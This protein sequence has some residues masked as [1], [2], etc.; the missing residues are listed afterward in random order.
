VP[1]NPQARTSFADDSDEDLIFYM[2]LQA[3]D[4]A[5]A[6]EAWEEFFLRHREYVLGVCRR[7]QATLGDLGVE[8]LA[9]ETLIRVFKKAY[10][11]NPLAN[12]DA[13]QARAR[14]RAWLGRIANRLFLSTLRRTPAIEFVDEP[15]AT[16]AKKAAQEDP[17][18]EPGDSQ[19][20]QLLQEGLRTLTLREREVLLA[21]YAWYEPGAGCQRMPSAELAALTER[22]Q[23]TSVNI[24]QIRSRAFDKLQQYI[25]D[26]TDQ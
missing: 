3:D 26:R 24:R 16:V 22:F 25:A 17:P 7:F 13:R 10:T 12:G 5:S 1:A 21:S 23:T 9:Q 20:R 19:R 4:A 2:S 6:Q 11:F 14:I 15:F 18:S 8:D